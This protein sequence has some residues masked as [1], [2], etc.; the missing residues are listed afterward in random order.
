MA[1]QFLKM[2]VWL[3]ARTDVSAVAKLLWCVLD[4]RGPESRWT[5]KARLLTAIGLASPHA[6]FR[7]IREL[8]GKGL[9][10]VG[11]RHGRRSTYQALRPNF[12]PPLDPTWTTTSPPET[13]AQRAP[14]AASRTPETGAQRAPVA[15]SRTPET[16]AQ[17]APVTG[18]FSATN[19]CALRTT[20]QTSD[21]FQRENP[22]RPPLAGQGGGPPRRRRR[23]TKLEQNIE[24]FR[25]LGMEEERQ[26]REAEE[27]QK[28]EAEER[29]KREAEERQRAAGGGSQ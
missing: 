12:T 28:R 4:D 5:G 25:R 3:A 27:R 16:G 29:Q 13:G 24:R 6:L 10:L 7:A 22:P 26:K 15:A 9:L 18:A 23:M 20:F 19:R 8:E 11:R 2:P 21:H 17:R 14:V 1:E